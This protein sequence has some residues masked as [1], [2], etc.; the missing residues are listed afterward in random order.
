MKARIGWIAA[1]ALGAACGADI[2]PDA[3]MSPASEQL[4]VAAG[5]FTMGCGASD[6]DC[7]P[8]SSPYND[9]KPAHQVTLS[10]FK[11]DR[12]EVTQAAYKTCVDAAKC[13]PPACGWDP[14]NKAQ[15]PVVCVDW[16]QAKA[17]CEW[18]GKRLPSEAEWEKA[19]RGTDGRR[20]PWGGDAP[21][22]DHANFGE[23]GGTTKAVGTHA[24]GASPFGMQ[25]MA[26]NVWEW[27]ADWYGPNNY[28]AAPVTDPRGPATGTVRVVRGGAFYSFPG[29]LRVSHRY[30]F[31]PGAVMYPYLGFRCAK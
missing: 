3:N 12:T 30:A 22:C 17:F 24:L 6:T 25:D 29:T 10:A 26:G 27:T 18:A 4:D 13:S 7:G 5:P 9:E 19:A 21:T 28:P 20:Y 15:H 31:D 2:V 23:C 16:N 11:L 14:A 8:S 1:A